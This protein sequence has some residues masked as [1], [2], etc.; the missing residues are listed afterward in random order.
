MK[1]TTFVLLPLAALVSGMAVADDTNNLDAIEVVSDNLSPQKENVKAGNTVKV[2]QATSM[3][4]V[5]RGIPGV[6]V[7]GARSVVQRYN[8]RGVSEEYLAITVDGARQNGYAFH[9]SGNYGIDPEILKRVDIDVGSNSIINGAGSLGGAIRFET[10]DAADLLRQGENFGAKVKWSYGSNGDSNQATTTLYGRAGNLDLLGYFNY[11]HQENNEDGAGVENANKGKLQNYLL[12]AK[13]NISNDQWIKASAEHY[14]NSAF[15]CFRANMAQCIGDAPTNPDKAYA[16]IER[17]TYTLGY[18]YSPSD[19]PLINVKANAY[20]TDTTTGAMGADKAKV[21]TYGG[22]LSNKSELDLGSTHHTITVGGEYYHTISQKLDS[23]VDDAKL[24]NTSL[25]LED[26]ISFGALSV[27][28][29]IRYD[30]YT[31]KLADDFDKNFSR[32]SKALGLKYALTDDFMVFANYTELFKGPDAGEIVLRGTNRLTYDKSL[33]ATKGDNKEVGFSY[34]TDQLFA[35]DDALTFTAK[36][37]NTHYD[38]I[39]QSIANPN[40]GGS[41]YANLGKVVLQGV[42]ASAKYSINNITAHITYA[43]ARSKQVENHNYAAFPDTGDR[44]TLGLS[45]QVPNA[46]VEMGWNTIWVRGIDLR[47]SATS[48]VNKESYSVSNLYVT[49]SPAQL[50][51]LEL[52]AGIDNVFNKVYKDQSTQYYSSVDNELGRNYKFTISYK[53]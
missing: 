45:Y 5:L 1:K 4:D 50:P 51:D 11:R 31:A 48:L 43:R 24:S 38:N 22:T 35:A 26:Q 16:G 36:Y 9:H 18:G 6:N 29:G 2:R 42:E 37:F 10:V 28:P 30:Y 47:S 33:E 39:S 8:I 53:F 32:V 27:I 12:K 52:T 17:N 3:A 41:I 14:I 13:Y 25:Y 49:W 15:S 7:N 23:T 44:Y 20:T 40:G 34:V 46:Q 21:K 19:N